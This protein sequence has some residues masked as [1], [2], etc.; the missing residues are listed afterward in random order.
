LDDA[1]RGALEAVERIL[2]RGGEADAVLRAVVAALH[3]RFSYIAIRFADGRLVS[4]GRKADGTE[5]PVQFQ[6][7]TVAELELSTDDPVF[8]RRVATLIS[9]Y[10]NP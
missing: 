1:Q 8:A 9:P 10:C 6:E 3:D 5:V 7:R 4:A 2:N